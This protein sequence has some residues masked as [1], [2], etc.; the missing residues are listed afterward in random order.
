[1]ALVALEEADSSLACLGRL[2]PR[3]S[4]RR[5]IGGREQ[6]ACRKHSQRI[7]HDGLLALKELQIIKY[8]QEIY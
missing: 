3:S 2:E 7:Y 1:M 5:T 8:S 6:E 4:G